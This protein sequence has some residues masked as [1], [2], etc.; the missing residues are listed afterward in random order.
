MMKATR[1]A[2]MPAAVRMMS[3][4]LKKTLIYD[5][6]VKQG[7]TMVGIPFKKR[8]I[9]QYRG[10]SGSCRLLSRDLAVYS[11]RASRLGTVSSGRHAGS[12]KL[13]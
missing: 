9:A 10:A 1:P 5:E 12:M 7:G 2:R 13:W 11:A 3:A 6:H 8:G 4:G